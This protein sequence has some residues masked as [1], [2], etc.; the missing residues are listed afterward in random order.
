MSYLLL[1]L[2]GI[3]L[4]LALERIIWAYSKW[5]IIWAYSKWSFRRSISKKAQGGPKAPSD[6]DY[7][8]DPLGVDDGYCCLPIRKGNVA[9]GSA[10]LRP[11][12]SEEV[13]A[14]NEG[15]GPGYVYVPYVPASF[16]SDTDLDAEPFSEP[17]EVLDSDPESGPREK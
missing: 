12:S 4:G 16:G 2:I 1:I 13:Q 9:Q 14:W 17:F 7:K 6:K 5:R 10:S 11:P 15:P 8:F 3:P